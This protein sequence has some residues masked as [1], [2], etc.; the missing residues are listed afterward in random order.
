MAAK[1]LT[2]DRQ[3]AS[4]KAVAGAY[5]R[6]IGQ[7]PGLRLRVFPSG[8]KQFEFRYVAITGHRHRLVL[9]AYPALSLSRARKKAAEIRLAVQ[10]GNDP[11]AERLEA[12]EQAR[13]GETLDQLAESYWEAAK[14]GLHGGRRRPK[15]E[16]TLE[17]ER[18]LW[19]NHIRT[20]LGGRLFSQ[21]R[22]SDCKAFM[23]DVAMSG[24]SPSSVA[25]IGG[26]LQS[27]LT[28]AVLEERLEANPMQG[29]ARPLA[30]NS[31]ERMFGDEALWTL[32]DTARIA[33]EPRSPDEKTAGV[34]ARLEASM[35]LAL[36]LLLLTLT[37]RNEIAGALKAE[38]DRD[39][40]LWVIPSAR[41]KAKHPHV[42]PLDQA[43][44]EVVEKAWRLDPESPFLFPSERVARQ[45]LD[46]RSVTRA[47]ART[48]RR[49]NLP[50]GSPHD[51]R[52]SGATTLTGRYGVTRFIVGLVLGHTP[53]D[54]SAVTAVYDRYTYVAEK[55]EA[56][57]LWSGHLRRDATV[58]P[59]VEQDR[60]AAAADGGLSDA[61]HLSALEAARGEALALC[62]LGQLHEAVLMLSMAL[63]RDP[64][65]SQGRQAL[66]AKAGMAMAKTGDRTEVI[67]WVHAV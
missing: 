13:I 21:L 8:L 6:V 55:R 64:A 43:C 33:S 45:P 54:G 19:R 28:Y 29:L 22:R 42:V 35:G 25:S 56:L 34:H 18:Q 5:E 14:V 9:G 65:L 31:R 38:F 41:A 49:R 1:S 58:G 63:G 51:V 52:R 39:A 2:T 67:D 10:D 46:P 57:R 47:I 23:R 7:C 59:K 32:W 60:E 3:V 37:R 16:V 15:R 26:V 50:V 30:L 27:V 24:L 44:L 40:G 20:P 4:L 17:N 12:R 61:D 53:T 66:L 11:V 48:C 62:E 36:Q